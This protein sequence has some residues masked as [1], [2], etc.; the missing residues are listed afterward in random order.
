MPL[1]LDRDPSGHPAW[2]GA[3]SLHGKPSTEF[4]ET[5][6]RCLDIGLINNMPDAALEATE[7]QFLG[8]LDGAADGLVVRVTL[9]AL[10]DVPRT[11]S[12]R[13]HMS[14]FYSGLDDLWDR[15]VDG[16]IVTG[17]EP[18]APNLRDEPYWSSLAN[19]LEWAEHS[20]HST[21]WSCLAAHA[22]LL[23]RDGIGRRTLR[24]KRFGVFECVRVDRKSVV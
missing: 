2:N 5:D 24:D 9:Y 20:T 15:H 6:A 4:R 16:L 8:L 10:P 23:H 11:D 7:R 3:K 13:R 21:I 1:R 12:G 17:T 19:V 14:S 18:R 22:A